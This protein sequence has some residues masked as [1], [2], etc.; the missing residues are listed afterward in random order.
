MSVV[1]HSYDTKR[2][3]RFFSVTHM[4]RFPCIHLYMS[5]STT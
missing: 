2:S 5:L 1:V 3:R 4:I